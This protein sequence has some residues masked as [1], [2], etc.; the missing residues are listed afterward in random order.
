MRKSNLITAIRD[1]ERFLVRAKPFM[2]LD[3]EDVFF[4]YG[5]KSSAQIKRASMDLSDSLV[6]LRKQS[7]FDRG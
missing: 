2:K 7:Y 1:A 5:C 6:L 4:R 3:E